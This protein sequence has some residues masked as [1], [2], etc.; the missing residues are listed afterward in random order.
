M[1]IFIWVTCIATNGLQVLLI[2]IFKSCANITGYGPPEGDLADLYLSSLLPEVEY[3]NA[4]GSIYAFTETNFCAP[5]EVFSYVTC[6]G[7]HAQLHI[8][9]PEQQISLLQREAAEEST[10]LLAKRRNNDRPYTD[11]DKWDY[12]IA[13]EQ[14]RD[15]F[16]GPIPEGRT[17]SSRRN[18]QKRRYIYAKPAEAT[19]ERQFY[20]ASQAQ[21]QIPMTADEEKNEP[22]STRFIWKPMT[23]AQQRPY[24]MR[25]RSKK[26]HR[27]HHTAWLF[28][29]RQKEFLV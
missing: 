20:A 10:Q 15:S 3:T 26:F 7:E 6:Q 27:R 12:S 19:V 29:T 28:V 2:T 25:R 14:D 16:P 17:E 21:P 4:E 5:D 8:D 18:R 13:I 9:S 23:Y 11:N 22:F 1:V 24:S